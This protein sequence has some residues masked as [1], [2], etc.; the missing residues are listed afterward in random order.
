[1]EML[2]FDGLAVKNAVLYNLQSSNLVQDDPSRSIQ[3]HLMGFIDS[4]WFFD[5]SKFSGLIRAE[6]K[7]EQTIVQ[8]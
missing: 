4:Y 6:S 2:F 1:M 5:R 3:A 7:K 8:D